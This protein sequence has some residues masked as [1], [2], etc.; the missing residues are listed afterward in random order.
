[1]IWERSLSQGIEISVTPSQFPSLFEK[2]YRLIDVLRDV[3]YILRHGASRPTE[4]LAPEEALSMIMPGYP[5]QYLDTIN[6]AAS[7]R[8]SNDISNTLLVDLFRLSN[9]LI[10]SK[11]ATKIMR[12]TGFDRPTSFRRLLSMRSTT[13]DALVGC[14]FANAMGRKH[15]A[16]WRWY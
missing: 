1:M 11:E 14:F 3:G 9:N 6:G 8:L 4:A 5:G 2:S 16:S 13:T 15:L 12:G 10:H 7:L